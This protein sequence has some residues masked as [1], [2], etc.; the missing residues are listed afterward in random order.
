M[1]THSSIFAWRIPPS[2]SHLP[3]SQSLLNAD[4]D[5]QKE[6]WFAFAL[7]LDLNLNSTVSLVAQLV[8]NLPVMQETWV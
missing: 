5:R 4:T 8:K 1:A 2:E 6:A 3:E 7:D